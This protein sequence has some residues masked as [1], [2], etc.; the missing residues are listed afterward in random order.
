MAHNQLAVAC[1]QIVEL[2]QGVNGAVPL[3][4]RQ[5]QTEHVVGGVFNMK[6]GCD[7][8]AVHR[9]VI[10]THTAHHHP[11]LVRC[12]GVLRIGAR[13]RLMFVKPLRCQFRVMR[14]AVVLVVVVVVEAQSGRQLVCL[15]KVRFKQQRGI[16]ILLPHII[17][18]VSVC[19]VSIVV[20]A[21]KYQRQIGAMR[22]IYNKGILGK[23][24]EACRLH[25]NAVAFAAL[26]C[27]VLGLA[28]FAFF[29]K[30]AHGSLKNVA[31]AHPCP[32]VHQV[33]LTHFRLVK[34]AVVVF[35]VV[36]KVILIVR[37][38]ARAEF[39]LLK[40]HIA[41]KVSLNAAL[42]VAIQVNLHRGV[43][44]RL[45][46]FHVNLSRNALIAVLYRS[47]ALRHLYALHPRSRHIAQ[48]VRCG[49]S[50]EVGNV[51]AQHL[52]IAASQSEQLYLFGPSGGI[53]VTHV[54]RR[55]G[56]KTL[57]Q[58][59]ASSL[60]QFCARQRKA[61]FGTAHARHAFAL[62]CHLCLAE[63]TFGGGGYRIVKHILCLN[64]NACRQ[65]QHWQCMSFSQS[66]H[67]ISLCRFMV[68]R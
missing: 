54:H 1:Q 17:G 55:V 41:V 34:K 7:K 16:A 30:A 57:A 22:F 32:T 68:Q 66:V 38:H 10:H 53:A 29:V 61:I 42:G 19:G 67:I 59:A 33:A 13:C 20:T 52:H 9:A 46:I 49:G 15:G 35:V 51:L 37:Q 45:F 56:G 4:R 24:R 18:A 58:I 2:A 47:T 25:V 60:E 27:S 43:G 26:V 39:L 64:R 63:L 14:Q 31:V 8:G 12:K 62:P 23:S 44:L 11:L 65:G 36:A 3:A 28:P 48:S 6:T 5:P 21:R 50:S 40:M